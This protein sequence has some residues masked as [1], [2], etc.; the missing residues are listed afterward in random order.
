MFINQII[1]F[2]Q[3]LNENGF[4]ISSDNIHTFLSVVIVQT[5]I[6]VNK[7]I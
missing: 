3:F 6:F 4:A 1:E 2:I 7:T 5:T